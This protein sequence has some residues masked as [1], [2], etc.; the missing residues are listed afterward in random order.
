MDLLLDALSQ[1]VE[2]ILGRASGPLNFRLVMMPTVVTVLAIRAHL[3][4]VRE[5]HPIYLGAFFTSPTER[6]RLF[7]SGLRDFG[8]VFVVACVLDSIYQFIVFRAFFPIEMLIIA[9]A[10]AIVPYFLIRGPITRI[11]TLMQGHRRGAAGATRDLA[12]P[13]SD[14]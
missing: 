7:R 4:D 2:R 14:R 1:N 6:R 8:K 13:N 3:K 11:V 5:G 9:L 12:H 10:C